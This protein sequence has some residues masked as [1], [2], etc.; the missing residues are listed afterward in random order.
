MLFRSR[1]DR[2]RDKAVECANSGV[3]GMSFL[4]YKSEMKKIEK[5]GFEVHALAK[6]PNGEML[7]SVNWDEAFNCKSLSAEQSF[8]AFGTSEQVPETENFAQSL[9]LLA[10][11]KS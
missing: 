10:T 9:Y 1:M 5:M 8:Y 4:L 3:M 7:C 6:A 2:F 11:R